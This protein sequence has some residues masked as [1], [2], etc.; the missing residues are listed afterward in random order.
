[1]Y[2]KAHLSSL[3]RKSPRLRFRRERP[4]WCLHESRFRYRNTLFSAPDDTKIELAYQAEMADC[5]YLLVRGLV[6]YPWPPTMFLK[7]DRSRQLMA[8]G[9]VVA[10]LLLPRSESTT[11]TLVLKRCGRS[12]AAVYIMAPPNHS[13]GH[14]SSPAAQSS[15]PVFQPTHLF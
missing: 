1:M 4:R 15:P 5:W 10:V 14:I 6:C 12:L 13:S 3:E 7:M 8:G 11:S 2:L 9:P